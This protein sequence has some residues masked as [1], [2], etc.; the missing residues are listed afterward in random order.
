M[1]STAYMGAGV[2]RGKTEYGYLGY[3][4]KIFVTCIN[5]PLPSEFHWNHQKV[6]KLLVK[7]WRG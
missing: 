1:G 5:R 4:L 3:L 6:Q 2:L 7:E